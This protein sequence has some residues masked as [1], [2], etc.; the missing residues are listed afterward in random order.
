MGSGV[1]RLAIVPDL[2]YVTCPIVTTIVERNGE[3]L[4]MPCREQRVC[5]Q[6]LFLAAGVCMHNQ[7][8]SAYREISRANRIVGPP[9][10]RG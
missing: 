6:N 9:R 8:S 2:L 5:M 1:P 3:K 4:Y 7:E 10:G